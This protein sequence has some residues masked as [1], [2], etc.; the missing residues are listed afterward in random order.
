MILI[1]C[2]H[3]LATLVNDTVVVYFVFHY[4]FLFLEFIR[5]SNS[6]LLQLLPFNI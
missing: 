6:F 5:K 4:T 3:R 1:S 2:C